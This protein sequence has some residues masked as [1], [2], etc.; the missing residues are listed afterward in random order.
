MIAAVLASVAGNN[1]HGRRVVP[2]PVEDNGRHIT[3][4]VMLL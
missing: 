3:E 1:F 2:T 4:G